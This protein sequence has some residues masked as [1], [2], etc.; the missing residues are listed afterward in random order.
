ML[1]AYL[2]NLSV[3]LGIYLILSLSLQLNLGYTGLNNLGIISFFSVGA[4]TSALF[5][6]NGS[7]FLLAFLLSGL[8]PSV[9]AFLLSL[10]IR[11]FKGD[12]FA[13]STL[14]FYFIVHALIL[15]LVFLTKGPMGLI[16]IPRPNIFGMVFSSNFKFLVLVIIIDFLV[17]FFIRRVVKSPFGMLMEAVRDNEVAARILGKDIFKVKNIS[18][19]ISAF[20]VGIAGSL[21]AHYVTYIDPS[22]FSMMQLICVLSMV[23]VGGLGTLNGVLI[24]TVI[25]MLLPE[26][27]RFIGFSSSVIGPMREIIYSLILLFILL[28][29]PKGF[30]GKI[31]LK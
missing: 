12:Y 9:L 1:S 28:Y 5:T 26:P 25:L 24:S 7:S 23:I 11:K 4:Y 17:Y 6:L 31:E 22:S 29:K 3:F 18:L 20:F 15:N 2:T 8:I 30:F 10:I 14:F 21:Y 13:L 19:I 27:L 16:D